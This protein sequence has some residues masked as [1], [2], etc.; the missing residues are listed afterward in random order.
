MAE[1]VQISKEGKLQFE[2]ELHELI[3]TFALIC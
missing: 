3:V 2:E 1:K